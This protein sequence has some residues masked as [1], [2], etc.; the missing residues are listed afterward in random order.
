MKKVIYLSNCSKQRTGFARH[1]KAVLIGLRKAGIEVVEVA[2]G[3]AKSSPVLKSLPWK[4]YGTMPDSPDEYQH[5]N[6][7]PHLLEAMFFGN[8]AID[9]IIK[10]EK[11]DAIILV[12]D[13]WKVAWAFFKPWFNRIPTLI[14]TPVDSSPVLPLIKDNAHI[15]KNIW[16]KAEFA[17]R[18]LAGVGIKSKTVPLITDH[19]KFYP[20]DSEKRKALRSTYG[21]D[22]SFVTG[23]V[24]RNQL[25]KLV[26]TLLRGFKEFKDKHPEANAK[27]LL[28]TNFEEGS[29]G[30]WRIKESMSQLGIPES[31]VYCTYICHSCKN[32]EVAPHTGDAVDCVRCGA[33]SSMRN[34]SID[35]GVTDDELNCIYNI[36]D[37]YCH[38]ATSGGFE[39]PM[40]EA[41]LAGLPTATCNYS[42]GETFCSGYSIPLQH[43]FYDERESGFRKSQPNDGEVCKAMEQVYNNRDLYRD[44]VCPEARAWALEKFDPGKAIQNY[45]DFVNAAEADFDYEF[46]DFKNLDYPPDYSISSNIEF[47]RDLYKGVFGIDLHGDNPDVKKY[48]DMLSSISREEVVKKV[49]AIAFEHNQ[50]VKPVLIDDFIIKNDNKKVIYIANGLAGECFDLLPVIEKLIEKYKGCDFYLSCNPENAPIFEHLPVANVLPF[51]QSMLNPRYLGGGGNWNGW[52]DEVFIP[53][54]NQYWN[55]KIIA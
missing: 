35:L 24:F 28:H 31:D 25:R 53:L 51:H 54:S 17:E 52:F 44:K 16:V 48:S 30:G 3:V 9:E 55:H 26:P 50:K 41:T 47:V 2:C 33:K 23:F 37:F 34:P 8:N 39:S 14:H 13:I 29:S 36:M 6:G 20:L 11:P 7:T 38:P 5:L 43:T 21:L 27:L 4:A 12:E 32:V 19:S 46:Y 15:L 45:V 42:F 40:M 10:I 22:N 49:K 18:D 1:A